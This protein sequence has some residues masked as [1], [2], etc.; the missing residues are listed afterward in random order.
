MYTLKRFRRV[1]LL[2]GIIALIGGL[3][4]SNPGWTPVHGQESCRAGNLSTANWNTDFCN[5]QV[6]FGEILVGNPTK[7]GIPSVTD[8]SDGVR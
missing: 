1:A 6:D 8:P 2:T 7:N 5:S 3:L 4:T